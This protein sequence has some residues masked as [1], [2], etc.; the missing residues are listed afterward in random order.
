MTKKETKMDELK[1]KNFDM[2]RTPSAFYC[3]FE[4]SKACQNLNKHRG[5]TLYSEKV[6][7][8]KKPMDT[9]DIQWRNNTIRKC[10]RTCASVIVG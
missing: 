5:M 2:I 3:V 1:N 4:H 8:E 7:F 6:S 10:R 9:S